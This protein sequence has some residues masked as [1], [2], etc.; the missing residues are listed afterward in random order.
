MKLFPVDVRLFAG[1]PIF[2]VD[3]TYATPAER[4]S[5][6]LSRAPCGEKHFRFSDA[7]VDGSTAVLADTVSSRRVAELEV[8]S[9]VSKPSLG[10][11]MISNL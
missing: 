6:V 9:Q 3:V 10:V 11:R 4:G 1:F 8:T 7:E 2:A 5:R